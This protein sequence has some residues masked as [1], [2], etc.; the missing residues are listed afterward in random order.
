VH[1]KVRRIIKMAL[2]KRD[3][4]HCAKLL[5][6][7]AKANKRTG[8]EKRKRARR[9]KRRSR[10][11]GVY[12]ISTP[13]GRGKV[14][15]T[16]GEGTVDKLSCGREKRVAWQEDRVVE[17]GKATSTLAPYKSGTLKQEKQ[18]REGGVRGRREKKSRRS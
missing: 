18:G 17:A 7:E 2:S 3:T 4:N 8:R 10:V 15:K 1:Q 12:W 5:S 14:A 16:R 6:S 13:R 9:N 11:T